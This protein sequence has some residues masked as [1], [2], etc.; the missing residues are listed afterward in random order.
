M[1]ELLK[2]IYIGAAAVGGWAVITFAFAEWIGARIAQRLNLK[3]TKE[4]EKE[5]EKLKSDLTR[6]RD[7]LNSTISAFSRQ[8]QVSQNRR[9]TSLENLWKNIIKLREFNGPLQ[10]FFNI[11]QPQEYQNA[12]REDGFN[13]SLQSISFE[14][15][16]YLLKEISSSVEI[17]RPY[18]GIKLWSFFFIYRA[19]IGRIVVVFDKGRKESNIKPWYDDKHTME[20]LSLALNKE[21]LERISANKLL[22][23]NYAVDSLEQKILNEIEDIITGHSISE[24]S[25]DQ[26]RRNIQRIEDINIEIAKSHNKK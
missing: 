4:K 6:D 3:W 24:L 20:V 16:S 2:Q 13:I 26:A 12:L 10:L 5:I 15:I 18:L 21:E 23:L 8:Y 19:F 9:L 17:S 7:I 25:I 14:N 11:L 22:F 1:N